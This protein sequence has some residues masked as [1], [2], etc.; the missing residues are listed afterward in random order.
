MHSTR[1]AYEPPQS[2]LGVGPKKLTRVPGLLLYL[3]PSIL[4]G[5]GLLLALMLNSK[6]P[7]PIEW[8]WVLWISLGISFP[9]GI[10]INH[11]AWKTYHSPSRIAY[12]SSAIFGGIL[13][14]T[15]LSLGAQTAIL[16]IWRFTGFGSGSAPL[17]D[18][19]VLLCAKNS[20]FAI[21]LLCVFLIPIHLLYSIHC[22]KTT[23]PHHAA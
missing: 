18:N 10:V 17:P 4:Y 12:W 9:V 11:L 14:A 8:L 7:T 19:A 15:L 16:I 22:R 13:W 3:S 20:L 2:D 6:R 21:P 5:V 23:K 1:N